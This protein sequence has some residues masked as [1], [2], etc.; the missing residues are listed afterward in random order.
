MCGR[1]SW[2]SYLWHSCAH[3]VAG[4]ALRC[5]ACT[6]HLPP[7]THHHLSPPTPPA[8]PLARRRSAGMEPAPDAAAT[9]DSAGGCPAKGPPPPWPGPRAASPTAAAPLLSPFAALSQD[10]PAP[11]AAVQV[12]TAQAGA[13]PLLELAVAASGEGEVCVDKGDRGDSARCRPGG[14]AGRAPGAETLTHTCSSSCSSSA[15]TVPPTRACRGCLA[16]CRTVAGSKPPAS[17]G[18]GPP[19]QPAEGGAANKDGICRRWWHFNP[20][21]IPSGAGGALHQ[22]RQAAARKPSCLAAA[23]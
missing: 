10:Q 1:R 9:A 17:A 22:P 8:P 12:D 5:H 6:H 21:A 16:R 23:P 13:R 15:S 3:Q 14:R 19:G 11:V 4:E 20:R 2:H 7:A 18:C